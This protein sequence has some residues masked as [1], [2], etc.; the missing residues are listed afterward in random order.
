[1]MG[2]WAILGGLILK[3]TVLLYE[4]APDFPHPGRV[5]ELVAKHRI[6][7]LGLSPTLV[8]ALIPHGEE[9]VRLQ[10]SRRRCW[11]RGAGPW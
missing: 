10:G 1:M 3:G 6:T 9:A 4:G 5:F 8:R 2:P 7:H 11:T